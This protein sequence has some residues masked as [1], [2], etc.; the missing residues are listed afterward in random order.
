M[1]NNEI[2]PK[3]AVDV[4]EEYKG[5]PII[6]IKYADVDLDDCED[7][8]LAEYPAVGVVYYSA[9]EEPHACVIVGNDSG[10]V[11]TTAREFM[12]DEDWF[13][14]KFFKQ[15]EDFDIV[16]ACEIN[17]YGEAEDIE[18]IAGVIGVALSEF[19]DGGNKHYY[20]YEW[21]DWFPEKA[22]F[23]VNDDVFMAYN[24]GGI[25]MLDLTPEQLEALKQLLS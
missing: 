23:V 13:E 7:L 2:T 19:H 16:L 5:L 20:T 6:T 4:P 24:D 22:I 17:G 12:N 1:E 21:D 10:E 14:E 15:I 25:E 9:C 8:E 11:Q 3:M 18:E